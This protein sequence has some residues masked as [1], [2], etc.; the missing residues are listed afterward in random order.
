MKPI[1]QALKVLLQRDPL[2]EEIAKFYQIKEI[3]GFS[4]HDSVWSILLAFG[5]YEILYKEI[6]RHIT[7]QTRELLA[8]HKL[9]LESCA[10]ASE[11][12]MQASLVESVAKTTRE[13]ANR[14]VEA[15][16]VFASQELRRKMIFAIIGALA[17]AIPATGFLMWGTYAVGQHSGLV[18]AKT[19]STWIQSSEGQ[20]ART[21]AQLNNIQSMLE[22][23]SKYLTYKVGNFTYCV[24]YDRKHQRNFGWRIK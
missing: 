8:D 22:C 14:A 19:D 20:A 12:A 7:D 1:D 5:H 21:F 17:I 6:S 13:M 16:K 11:R 9:A 3:C 15:G 24:P 18:K 2:P 23:P 10:R 4:K